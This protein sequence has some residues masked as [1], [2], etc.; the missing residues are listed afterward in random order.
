[1]AT[2]K[3]AVLKAFLGCGTHLRSEGKALHANTVSNR[4]C[5]F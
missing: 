3:H 1:M 4:T 5:L 2:E